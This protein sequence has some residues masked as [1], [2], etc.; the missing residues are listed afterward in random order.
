MMSIVGLLVLL[1]VG[2]A[3]VKAVGRAGVAGTQRETTGLF[4]YL[5]M[6]VALLTFAVGLSG[7]MS[8]LLDRPSAGRAI[9]A[10]ELSSAVIGLPVFV[11]L[12][13]TVLG[14]LRTS[15][16]ERGGNG[17]SLYINVAVLTTL[18]VA[19][20]AIYRLFDEI[21]DGSGVGT[22]MGL[23]VVWAPLWYLHWWAWDR[24]GDSR[25]PDV[26]WLLGSTGGVVMATIGSVWILATA[27]RR[28]FDALGTPTTA[29]RATG[30][31]VE[32]ALMTL[33]IGAAV[34]SWHWLRT[35]RRRSESPARITYLLIVGVFGG[36][37]LMYVGAVGAL[38]S[39]LVWLFGEPDTTS[40]RVHFDSIA[41]LVPTALAG[42][43]VWWYHRTTLGPRR[44]ADRT[45]T[46]RLYSYLVAGVAALVTTGSLI[47]LG[48]VVLSLLAPATAVSRD[49]ATAN[50]VLAA[51]A[52]LVFGGPTWFIQWRDLEQRVGADEAEARSRVR[53]LY[54][55]VMLAIAGTVAFA[56]GIAT[57]STALGAITGERTGSVAGNLRVPLASLVGAGGLGVYHLR[58]YRTERHLFER[59]VP[60]E[61]TVVVPRDTDLALLDELQ[62]IAITRLEAQSANGTSVDLGA[63]QAAIRESEAERLLVVALGESIEAIPLA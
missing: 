26:Y 47:T 1:A 52:L 54:L 50:I 5:A 48:V 13:R 6:Y 12:A 57:L 30:D 33:V 34:W 42:A 37:V 60:R 51:I 8:G 24:F 56:A 25:R 49:V 58:R 10:G 63:I 45:E 61:V 46:D 32:H 20:T 3:V 21:L 55:L 59:D 53:R 35:G 16:V 36:V 41:V 43:A 14:R 62:G 9:S 38:V 11:A 39:V 22:E 29:V 7:V 2:G 4:V 28:I 19:A 44:A 23:V 17:W 27:A 18:T 31:D 15:E 40:A